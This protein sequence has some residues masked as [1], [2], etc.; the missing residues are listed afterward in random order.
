MRRAAFVSGTRQSTPT[1]SAPA[2]PISREQLAGP[3]AEVDPRH[4]E[5]AGGRGRAAVRQHEPLVVRRRQ[6]PAHESNSCTA[7]APASTCTPDTPRRSSAS[8]SSSS[9]HSP[10]RRASAPWCARGRGRTA[11]DQVA[12]ERE[13][14]SGEPDQRRRA[15]LGHERRTASATTSRRRD[16]AGGAGRRRRP[17]GSAAST[18]GPTP[19]TMSTPTPTAAS[20]TT[21]SENRIAA[22]DSVPARGW[23]VSS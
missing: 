2:P 1:T 5:A 9:C 16:R 14:R 12:G 15:E 18:T 17:C 13:R 21:M 23:R 8:R 4:A 20:G 11:L 7:A 6:A 3:D 10:G 19:G 22:L